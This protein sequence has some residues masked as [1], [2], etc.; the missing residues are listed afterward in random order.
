[1][2]PTLAQLENIAALCN[3]RWD[4]FYTRSKLASDPVYQAVVK[5]IGSSSLP[6][7]DIGCG[8]GLLAH[9]LRACGHTAPV[10]GFDYDQRK[11]D[12]AAAMVSKSGQQGLSF[13]AGDA[14]TGLPEFSG[15]VVILDILQFFTP[16]EQNTLIT[17]AAARVAPGGKLV[18]RTGLRDDSWRFR[19]TVLG[20]Y[21]AKITFW[22]KA[23]PTCY[24]DAEQF[25]D[26]LSKAGLQVQITPLWGGTP[27]NNHLIV[28]QR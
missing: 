28:A 5:E 19:V 24:P 9:Y 21:L 15:H 8:I 12:S 2:T 18:I 17:A 6:V 22:M 23:A 25:R 4:F 1:M 26:V 11:I 3:R 14:R 16:E 10:I 27:F 20:D 7:L 13:S